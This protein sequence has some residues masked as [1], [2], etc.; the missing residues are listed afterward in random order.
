MHTPFMAAM[1]K[2]NRHH[3]VTL[4]LEVRFTNLLILSEFHYNLY[5]HAALLVFV[6]TLVLVATS[7]VFFCRI[8]REQF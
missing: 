6:L 5:H 3:F 4:Y 8:A 1:Y 2:D 7:K